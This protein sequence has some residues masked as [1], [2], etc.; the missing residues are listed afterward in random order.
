MR[1][2]KERLKKPRGRPSKRE[3][4]YY[5][6]RDCVEHLARLADKILCL[7]V[8]AM[9]ELIVLDANSCFGVCNETAR[10]CLQAACRGAQAADLTRVDIAPQTILRRRPLRTHIEN[11]W[12]GDPR[13]RAMLVRRDASGV[14]VGPRKSHITTLTTSCTNCVETPEW[15]STFGGIGHPCTHKENLYG[16]IGLCTYE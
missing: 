11:V 13:A 10:Q 4:L 15:F 7:V 5:I 16:L 3:Q 1:K 2:P 14:I 9:I 12:C 6:H 8:L